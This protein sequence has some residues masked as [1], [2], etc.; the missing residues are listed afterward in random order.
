MQWAPD[1]TVSSGREA[2][3]FLPTFLQYPDLPHKLQPLLTV[4]SAERRVQIPTFFLLR[5]SLRDT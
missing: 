3:L 2:V 4:K 5:R 1:G